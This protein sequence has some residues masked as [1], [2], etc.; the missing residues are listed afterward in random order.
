MRIQLW[1]H[2]GVKRPTQKRARHVYCINRYCYIFQIYS[3]SHQIYVYPER[4]FLKKS[5]SF[6]NGSPTYLPDANPIGMFPLLSLCITKRLR[7]LIS[8]HA[9]KLRLITYLSLSRPSQLERESL[10]AELLMELAFYLEPSNL[11]LKS[12]EGASAVAR[13][14]ALY[15]IYIPVPCWPT[16]SL[17]SHGSA[18]ETAPIRSCW[19]LTLAVLP[20]YYYYYDRGAQF[21]CA[22]HESLAVES[23]RRLV[24]SA[25]ESGKSGTRRVQDCIGAAFSCELSR[26]TYNLIEP[27]V[28]VGFDSLLRLQQPRMRLLRCRDVYDGKRPMRRAIGRV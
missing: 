9:I 24:E 17:L 11:H 20:V 26:L 6:F 27:I 2:F 25:C 16:V 10:A 7:R 12:R 15:F 3:I 19:K 21:H 1:W 8:R 4:D 23:S 22:L 14:L 18:R 13:T 5:F 28:V